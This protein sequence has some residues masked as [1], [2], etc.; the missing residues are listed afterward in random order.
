MWYYGRYNGIKKLSYTS[1]LYI[2]Y[3]VQYYSMIQIFLSD[4]SRTLWYFR[5]S[6]HISAQT[7]SLNWTP[8]PQVFEQSVQPV[9][10]AQPIGLHG[11]VLH[12]PI[13][14]ASPRQEF[15]KSSFWSQTRCRT[16]VP[17][18]QDTVQSV[19]CDHFDQ[20]AGR[21]RSKVSCR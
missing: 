2:K 6:G 9:H 15:S 20:P 19:H 16:R 11:K 4:M 18:S 14:S 5:L 12:S 7:R 3:T 13:S 21:K 1:S 10:G 17:P 8:P